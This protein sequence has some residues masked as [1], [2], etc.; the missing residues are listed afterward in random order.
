MLESQAQHQRIDLDA[1]GGPRGALMTQELKIDRGGL[2][3][4]VFGVVFFRKIEGSLVMG[5]TGAVEAQRERLSVGWRRVFHW[6]NS[7]QSVSGRIL[8]P[9]PEMRRGAGEI[10]PGAFG[11]EVSHNEILSLD[12]ELE[13]AYLSIIAHIEIKVNV[14]VMKL[15]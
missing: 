12:K 8:R 5:E 15:C 11:D 10:K 13:Y 4:V 7:Q 2:T 14:W 3:V 9:R 6:E 1:D